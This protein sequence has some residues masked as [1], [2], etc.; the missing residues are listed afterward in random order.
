M[1]IAGKFC[2]QCK[3]PLQPATVSRLSGEGG[4]YKVALESIPVM[5]CAANHMRLIGPE[6]VGEALDAV[7]KGELSGVYAANQQGFLGRRT[8]CGKCGFEIVNGITKNREFRTNLPLESG[9]SMQITLSA[10]WIR[11]ATCGAEQLPR[12]TDLPQEVINA[13]TRAFRDAK[14]GIA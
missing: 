14:I 9:A 13:L 2:A 3:R 5:A 7:S 1:T 11:C 12:V 6:F 4:G 8:H 10:P